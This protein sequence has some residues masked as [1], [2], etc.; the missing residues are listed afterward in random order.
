MGRERVTQR[1]RGDKHRD[2]ERGNKKQVWN[3]SQ[4]DGSLLTS[5]INYEINA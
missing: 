3:Y 4:E 5:Y 2:E 1:Q